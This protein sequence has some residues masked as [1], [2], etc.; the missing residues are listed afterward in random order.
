MVIRVEVVV[1]IY[2]QVCEVPGGRWGHGASGASGRAGS[3][4]AKLPVQGSTDRRLAQI[5]LLTNRWVPN[6][7][8][9]CGCVQV[10]VALR[11]ALVGRGQ[12][13]QH[14]SYE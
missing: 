11:K 3:G 6:L 14:H 9:C 4:L 10:Q 8:R 7:A 1:D 2:R 5:T 13:G 12:L